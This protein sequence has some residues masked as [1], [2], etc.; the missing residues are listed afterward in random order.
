[1]GFILGSLILGNYQMTVSSD[2]RRLSVLG[3]LY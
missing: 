2:V 3:L 1:M